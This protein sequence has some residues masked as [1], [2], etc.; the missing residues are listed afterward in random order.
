LDRTRGFRLLEH[1]A[2]VPGEDVERYSLPPFVGVY[3]QA[4]DVPV[5]GMEK[6]ETVWADLGEGGEGRAKCEWGGRV[7]K[8]LE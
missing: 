5:V 8:G 4:A 6:V 3:E 2:S 7:E 1:G